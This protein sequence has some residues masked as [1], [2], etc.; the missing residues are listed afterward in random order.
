[1]NKLVLQEIIQLRDITNK[2][3][4]KINR[5]GVLPISCLLEIKKKTKNSA[6]CHE[7]VNEA[8][9]T[10]A[11]TDGLDEFLKVLN[12]SVNLSFILA[13][14]IVHNLLLKTSSYRSST[15]PEH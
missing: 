6:V 5:W 8:V 9:F 7:T 11:R 12:K 13:G 15:I 10:A 1:M 2:R 4:R 3:V 14:K